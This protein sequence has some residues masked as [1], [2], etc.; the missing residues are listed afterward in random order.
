MDEEFR[1]GEHYADNFK[2]MATKEIKDNLEG[3]CYTKTEGSYTKI[4]TQEEL[5]ER[6]SRLA[7]VAIELARIDDLKKS[8]MDEVKQLQTEPKNEHSH[9]LATIK[10][11][12]ERKEGALYLIDLQEKG[13]MY[14]F[15]EEGVCVDARPLLPGEKQMKIRT[16]GKA[17][18][19]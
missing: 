5:A 16:I 9:L 17:K 4:L 8:Y 11:K 1:I 14:F 7:D 6:K 3:I 12:T 13:M 18:N 2:G 10:H 15:D 19:E